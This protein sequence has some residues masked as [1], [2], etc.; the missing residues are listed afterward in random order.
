[1]IKIRILS[2]FLIVIIISCTRKESKQQPTPQNPTPSKTKELAAQPTAINNSGFIPKELFLKIAEI[3]KLTPLKDYLMEI[4]DKSLGVTVIAMGIGNHLD[5]LDKAGQ[6]KNISADADCLLYTNLIGNEKS[7]DSINFQVIEKNDCSK[8]F[9]SVMLAAFPL[10]KEDWLE[11]YKKIMESNF[12]DS[13]AFDEKPEF[14]NVL[15]NKLNIKSVTVAFNDYPID[16]KK[17]I[18]YIRTK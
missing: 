18:I 8:F 16:R 5:E 9:S 14:T 12:K 4:G 11:I 17:K 2:F 13:S 3:Q 1:M 7:S 6:H 15:T 10:L